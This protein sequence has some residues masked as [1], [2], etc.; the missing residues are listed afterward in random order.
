MKHAFISVLLFSLPIFAQGKEGDSLNGYIEVDYVYIAPVQNGRI[1][2]IFVEE[3]ARV[4]IGQELFDLDDVDQRGAVAS[5]QSALAQAEVNA[6]N[7]QTNFVRTQSL[8]N[9]KAVESAQLDAVSN[10]KEAADE[11]VIAARANLARAQ[12]QLE[13]REIVSPQAGVVQDIYFSRGEV[14]TAGTPIMAVRPDAAFKAIVFL[15]EP[16]RSQIELGQKI[17]VSCDGC[18]DGI[19]AVVSKIDNQPQYS[20]PMIFSREQRGRFVYRME[21]ELSQASNLTAGQPISLE[22]VDE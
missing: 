8:V 5:A 17:Q 13:E 15:P 19:Y 4:E 3:G 16:M 11:Q 14:I 10:Q 9:R 6:R 2:E 21:A 1:E 18:D 7:A 22:F 12:Y 20:P